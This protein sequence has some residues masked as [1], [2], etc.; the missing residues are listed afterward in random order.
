MQRCPKSTVFPNIKGHPPAIT[1]MPCCSQNSTAAGE[2][3]VLARTIAL[4]R[5]LRVVSYGLTGHNHT[6]DRDAF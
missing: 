6:P 3:L 1:L 2:T 4:L 5:A